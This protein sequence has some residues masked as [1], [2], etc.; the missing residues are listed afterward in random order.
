M[1]EHVVLTGSPRDSEAS[2]VFGEGNMA[3]TVNLEVNLAK[4]QE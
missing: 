3:M 1:F 4:P 2:E